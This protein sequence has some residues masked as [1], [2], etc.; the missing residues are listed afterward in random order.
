MINDEIEKFK[1]I[2]YRGF[3]KKLIVSSYP[4]I[5]VRIPVLRKIAKTINY[6]E[7]LQNYK[8]NT[9]ED[10]ILYGMVLVKEPENEK[11][12]SLISDYLKYIDC[13]SI[14]DCFCSNLHFV[15]NDLDK[16]FKWIGSFLEDN[17]VFYIRFGLVMLLKYYANNKYI[18]D[19]LNNIK[20]INNEEYYCRMAIAW[21]LCE[22]AVIDK[23]KVDKFVLNV[24]EEI[25]KMYN[26]KIKDSYRIKNKLS[27]LKL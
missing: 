7:Y 5:G 13:W 11:R 20:I 26:R 15:K 9:Y 24:S 6:D 17:R 18:D 12:I 14:C 23:K 27:V 19:I 25:K 16:Y 8:L 22:L 3:Q 2:K 4:L 1:D 21:L 10:I